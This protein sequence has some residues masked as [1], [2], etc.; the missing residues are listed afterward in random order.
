MIKDFG[1]DLFM[2]CYGYSLQVTL[3]GISFNFSLSQI[4]V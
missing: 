1:K 4:K 2:A 3:S